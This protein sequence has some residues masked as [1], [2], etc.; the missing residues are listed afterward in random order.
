MY[1]FD[2]FKIVGNTENNAITPL[3]E[4]NVIVGR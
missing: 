1:F 4:F 2:E 3:D